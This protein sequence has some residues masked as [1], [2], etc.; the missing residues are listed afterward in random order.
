MLGQLNT[1]AINIE[2]EGFINK[3]TNICV[4]DGPY[5]LFNDK[6]MNEIN[7]FVLQRILQMIVA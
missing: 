6:D 5:E 4:V 7:D 2:V 3:K 1:I